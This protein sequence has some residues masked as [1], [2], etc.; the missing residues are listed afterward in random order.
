MKRMLY[1]FICITLALLSLF[2]PN[3][4][5]GALRMNYEFEAI[6]AHPE[7]VEGL[8]VQV[9]GYAKVLDNGFAL[10]YSEADCLYDTR[11]NAIY[12]REREGY[13]IE[14]YFEGR[15][16]LQNDENNWIVI[17]YFLIKILDEQPF[18]GY[19]VVAENIGYGR[20][21][22]GYVFEESGEILYIFENMDE[23]ETPI[24]ISMYRLLG[25]PWTYDG[26]MVQVDAL[27]GGE[28]MVYSNRSQFHRLLLGDTRNWTETWTIIE[29][30][31]QLQLD[32]NISID[33]I[34]GYIV[35]AKTNLIFTFRF[36]KEN[37]ESYTR[38]NDSFSIPYYLLKDVDIHDKDYETIK[39]LIEQDE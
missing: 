34:L 37:T 2:I 19:A 38:R 14:E 33:K 7:K 8:A 28:T 12:V 16:V 13:N 1:A 31:L 4:T 5:A 39:E 22:S 15:G 36:F 25:D 30:K 20:D 21:D 10:Y 23:N 27:Y 18:D 35:D 26:K 6:L 32:A 29:R 11:E 24:Y 3:C 17:G 9:W